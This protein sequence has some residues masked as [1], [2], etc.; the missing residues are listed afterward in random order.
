M[1]PTL[2]QNPAVQH[3]S[4]RVTNRVQTKAANDEVTKMAEALGFARAACEEVAATP[5]VM[6][7]ESLEKHARPDDDATIV[8]ARSSIA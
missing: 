6:A 4:I 5:A 2:E 7:Q 1:A 3:V 8:V